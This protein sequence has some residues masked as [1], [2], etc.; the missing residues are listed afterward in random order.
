MATAQGVVRAVVREVLDQCARKQCPVNESLAAFM[1]K[2]VILDPGQ[3][4]GVDRELSKGDVDALTSACV[5]RLS[6]GASA[7]L[8]T[9]KMQTYMTSS[10]KTREEI[11]ESLAREDALRLDDVTREILDNRARTRDELEALYRKLIFYAMAKAKLG[12]PSDGGVVRESTAA[13]ESVMPPS[14]LGSFVSMERGKKIEQ[15]QELAAVVGGIRLYNKY[16]KKGG[17]LVPDLPSDLKES[18]GVVLAQLRREYETAMADATKMAA[19]LLESPDAPTAPAVRELQRNTWQYIVYLEVFLEEVCHAVPAIRDLSGLVDKRLDGIRATVQSKTAVPTDTIYP[20][21]VELSGLWGQ[22]Q[23]EQ[24]CLTAIVAHLTAMTS[25]VAKRQQLPDLIKA[26]VALPPAQA[27]VFGNMQRAF[28]QGVAAALGEPALAPA[29][30]PPPSETL[31]V[32]AVAPCTLLLPGSTHDFDNIS[33]LIGGFCP[34]AVA[35]TGVLLPADRSL[36]LLQFNGGVY[37]FSCAAH[38]VAFAKDVERT[39]EAVVLSGRRAAE[40]IDLLDLHSAVAV[41]TKE[42]VSAAFSTPSA[43]HKCDGGTQTEVHPVDKHI[44]KGYDWNEWEMRRKAIRLANL[45][46]KRTHGVQTDKSNYRRDNAAQVYPPKN[47]E[48]QT[49][50]D[51]GTSVPTPAIFVRGLRGAPDGSKAVPVQVVDL[52]LG[53]TGVTLAP[54]AKKTG[55]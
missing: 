27:A 16:C 24:N 23:G 32:E 46:T 33:L 43:S 9:I 26:D 51:A 13:F 7:A 45:R 12:P 25:W 42:N 34:I 15:M 44:V 20:M 39:L 54:S 55:K 37:G 3:S 30:A 17:A 22:L 18:L 53:I 5:A 8:D 21:F 6:D 14:E 10:F 48:T 29:P 36:G 28:S 11:F 19:S 31:S 1:V 35:Q 47:S 49:K 38:A 50:S 4:F 2:A 40:L 41:G 52:T